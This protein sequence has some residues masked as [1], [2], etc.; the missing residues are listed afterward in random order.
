E[1]VSFLV[2]IRDPKIRSTSPVRGFASGLF[3][4]KFREMNP[5]S[6]FLNY[7]IID[8]MRNAE[9]DLNQCMEE[10]RETKC[11]ASVDLANFDGE[12]ITYWFTLTD[13]VGNSD[14]SEVRELEVDATPPAI[15]D[16]SSELNG[17]GMQF[18][19]DITEENF[20]IVQYRDNEERKPKYRTLCSRLDDG[21]CDK[22][23]FFSHGDHSI[24]IRVLDKAGNEAVVEGLDFVV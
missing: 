15:N 13:I 1:T 11:E 2:D 23:K 12:E 14:E 9:V 24:D 4:V 6:L 5:A 3:M 19:I 21:I 22:K 10:G 17:R 7:G 16:F 8:D 20:Q 18:V